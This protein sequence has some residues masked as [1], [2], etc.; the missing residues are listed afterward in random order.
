ML[1]C[2]AAAAAIFAPLPIVTWSLI[3]AP[4]PIMTKSPNRD[5]A[6]D[7][8]I[9]GDQ[10]MPPDDDVVADLDQIVDLGAFA[11]DRI[12]VAAAVDRRVGADL[13]VVLDDDPADLRNLQMSGPAGNIAESVLA[14]ADARVEDDA[15]ADQRVDDG[16][17][18]ADRRFAADPHARRR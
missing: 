9:A 12:A 3:P 13:D 2:T 11:D 1:E 4:P 17:P 14:D 18:G 8:D 7:T 6:R 5:T 16:R 10:A 15:I